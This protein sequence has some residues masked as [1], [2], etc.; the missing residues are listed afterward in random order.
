MLYLS[1]GGARSLKENLGANEVVDA[2][3]MLATGRGMLS[4]ASAQLGGGGMDLR[5]V[6]AQAKGLLERSGLLGDGLALDESSPRGQ[7][8]AAAKGK[9]LA[10]RDE[11][12]RLM[13]GVASPGEALELLR[14]NEEVQRQLKAVVLGC[15]EDMVCGVQMPRIGGEKDWGTFEITGLAIQHFATAPRLDFEAREHRI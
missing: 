10:A 5:G 7:K 1:Y 8:I 4:Q 14:G 6:G 15:V 12:M 3:K 11:A 9:V 13:A 2:G